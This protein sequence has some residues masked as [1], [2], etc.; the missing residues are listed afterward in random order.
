M[1]ALRKLR[2]FVQGTVSLETEHEIKMKHK[3]ATELLYFPKH[4]Q[5]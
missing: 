4:R 2:C 3:Y 5:L 1:A